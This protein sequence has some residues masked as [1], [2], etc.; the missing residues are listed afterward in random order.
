MNG[1]TACVHIVN[2]NAVR[3][4]VGSYL[5]VD[6][7]VRRG[8][9]S[10]TVPRRSGNL[11]KVKNKSHW[12]SVVDGWLW[13]SDILILK[14]SRHFFRDWVVQSMWRMANC[15][16]QKLRTNIH[17]LPRGAYSDGLF[18]LLS[19]SMCILFCTQVLSMR[20]QKTHRSSCLYGKEKNEMK[21]SHKRKR[22]AQE[23]WK[24]RRQ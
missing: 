23:K 2:N 15:V 7:Q 19:G 4:G 11:C 13:P 24:M 8:R 17:I 22:Q 10:W 16:H 18:P 9:K 12:F 6:I 3:H 14:N 20:L 21:S 5:F 1:S